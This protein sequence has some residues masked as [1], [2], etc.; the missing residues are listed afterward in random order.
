MNSLSRKTLRGRL[1]HIGVRG[2]LFLG[3]E[4][5]PIKTRA[6]PESWRR[7]H[8]KKKV[9]EKERENQKERRKWGGGGVNYLCGLLADGGGD[10]KTGCDKKPCCREEG[11]TP[12]SHADNSRR[13]YGLRK[14]STK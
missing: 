11:N 14:E 3:V 4:T 6:P 12:R 13:C 7:I 8:R 1:P 2:V 9:L 10:E 5:I